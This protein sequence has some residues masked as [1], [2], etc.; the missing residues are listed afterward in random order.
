MTRMGRS[1]IFNSLKGYIR[2]KFPFVQGMT[3]VEFAQRLG[4]SKEFHPLILDTRSEEEYTVSHL[5][6]A[7]QFDVGSDFTAA[8]TLKEVSKDKPIVVYCSVGY[9]SAKVAQ[10]LAQAGFSQVFNLE[11]GLFQW[12]NEQRPLFHNG[13]PTQL[14]H[15][16]NV[17][18]GRLLEKHD[19]L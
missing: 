9:R 11:G 3:T 12:S 19:R 6:A 17:V 2:L 4:D 5:A 10:Q 13:Q 14:V 16:Y 7:R 8:P 1:L 15:P 18:W